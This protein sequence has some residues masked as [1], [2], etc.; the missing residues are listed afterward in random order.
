MNERE[1][2]REE[3]R[4]R[5]R[6]RE[7]E[8]EKRERE[9]RER[10]ERKRE[11]EK[12]D[13]A[14]N[15]KTLC[16]LDVVSMN[17]LRILTM[18]INKTHRNRLGLREREREREKE[19]EGGRE[20]RE[21]GGKERQRFSGFERVIFI[22]GL[23]SLLFLFITMVISFCIRM[24]AQERGSFHSAINLTSNHKR[25]S[26]MFTHHITCLLRYCHYYYYSS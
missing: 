24:N 9:R 26:H 20:T 19:T 3:K 22:S 23:C 8:R 6:E 11:R 15:W 5:E 13:G 17:D 16:W 2:E 4:E 25:T 18:R 21:D 7:K 12:G 14:W 1:R 10:R